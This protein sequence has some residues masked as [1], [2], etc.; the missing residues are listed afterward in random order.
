VTA[1]PQVVGGTVREAQLVV[2]AAPTVAAWAGPV[3][4]T[5]TAVVGGQKVVREARPA[6]VVWPVPQGLGV[7]T[8]TRLD[9]GLF[10]AV[11]DKALYQATAKLDKPSI[12]HGENGSLK[13]TLA[14]LAP[15]FKVP[16]TVLPIP[17]ELPPGLVVNNNQPINIA[18]DKSEGAVPVVVTPGVQPGHY[19]L[20]L[21]TQALVPFNK[22]PKAPNKQPTL[23][24][25]PTTPVSLTVVP[26]AVGNLALN[27]PAPTLKAGT[28]MELRVRVARLFDYAGEFKV[29]LVLPPGTAGVEA[30]ATVIPAGKDEAPLV[31]K[32]ATGAA[33]GNRA[34]LT[35]RATATAYGATI[36]QQMQFNV[37]VVK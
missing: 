21:R 23:I 6:S 20:V 1:A 27:N 12:A 15:D 5:G 10:L 4:V 17:T 2:T 18:P 26:K 13:V 35:L 3:R 24:V 8:V 29:E 11:R 36:T 19:T 22:D 16:V 25:Q 30:A 37:N 28:Q 33:P 9:H 32:A 14:R 31:L 7:P 34:N